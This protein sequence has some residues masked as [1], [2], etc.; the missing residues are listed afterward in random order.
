MKSH[1]IN[2]SKVSGI[3]TCLALWTSLKSRGNYVEGVRGMKLLCG[4]GDGYGD[5]DRLDAH[6]ESKIAEAVDAEIMNMRP[7][8]WWSIWKARGISTTWRFNNL[9]YQKTLASALETLESR[10]RKNAATWHLF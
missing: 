10:L 8:Q 5:S 3:E 9:D 6:Q 7:A 2:E 4:D 1:K